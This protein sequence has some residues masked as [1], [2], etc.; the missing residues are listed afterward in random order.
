VKWLGGAALVTL[1]AVG[2]TVAAA[3][4]LLITLKWIIA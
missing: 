2:L 4:L 1:A 3:K